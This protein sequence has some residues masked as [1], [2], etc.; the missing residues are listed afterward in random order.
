MEAENCRLGFYR[1]R[2]RLAQAPWEPDYLAYVTVPSRLGALVGDHRLVYSSGNIQLQVGLGLLSRLYTLGSQ[3][4]Q[5]SESL[6]LTTNKNP[7]ES[8]EEHIHKDKLPPVVL[9]PDTSFTVSSVQK[10][11]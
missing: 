1:P 7:D 2:S 4:G 9:E 6:K 10:T 5:D 8:I 11:S 3:P